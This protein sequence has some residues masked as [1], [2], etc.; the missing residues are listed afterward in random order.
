MSVQPRARGPAKSRG[1]VIV[2]QILAAARGGQ[3]AFTFGLGDLAYAGGNALVDATRGEAL[4]EA[5]T[6]RVAAERERDR[7]D[8][9]H[10]RTARTVGEIGG[11]ALGLVALGPL[12]G[13][14]AGGTRIAQ[15]AAIGGREIGAIGA[16]GAGLGIGGQ[17]LSD[18]VSGRRGSVG[19]YLGAAAGGS[20]G[21]LGSVRG[22]PTQAAALGGAT[23]SIAQDELNGR[24]VDLHEAALAAHIAGYVAAP[25]G[26]AGRV[27]SDRLPMRQ[28]GKLGDALGVGRTLA[29]GDWP[30]AFQK[31]YYLKGAEAKRGNPYTVVDQRTVRGLLTEQ[32]FGRSIDD[33]SKN[34]NLALEEFGPAGYRVDHFLPRDVGVIVAYPAGN[35]STRAVKQGQKREGR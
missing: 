11:T 20:V 1:D 27:V 25:T 15:T 8:M 5:W 24:P 32:K 9:K 23:T 14:L 31:R 13:I 35:A 21:A 16:A 33:L 19:D 4:G 29:N 3:D 22:R 28:K 18:R 12:D 34:Q 17:A 2:D 26:L 7:Y 10:Y 30:K 6:R